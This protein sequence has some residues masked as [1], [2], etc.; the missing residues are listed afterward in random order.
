M[1]MGCS[2]QWKG[3]AFHA[4]SNAT[5]LNFLS[6]RRAAGMQAGRI[7]AGEKTTTAGSPGS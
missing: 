3:L 4:D 1:D 5:D 2:S 6:V 7:L